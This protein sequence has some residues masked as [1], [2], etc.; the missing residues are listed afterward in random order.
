MAAV[1]FDIPLIMNGLF[2][3]IGT[4]DPFSG[5]MILIP[6]IVLVVFGGGFE[7]I[8]FCANA[9]KLLLNG[10]VWEN[11]NI[12]INKPQLSYMDTKVS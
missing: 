4:L 5:E 9:S 8:E 2:K 6:P 11:N 12:S 1:S 10:L 7:T 3:S